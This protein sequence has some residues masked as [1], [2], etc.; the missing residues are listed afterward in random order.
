MKIEV[1]LPTLSTDRR[2]ISAATYWSLQM[3]L[4]ALMISQWELIS[5]EFPSFAFHV[6][7]SSGG[8]K[9]K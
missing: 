5:K 2:L 8:K 3:D 7:Y 9:E 4:A 1:S 6:P